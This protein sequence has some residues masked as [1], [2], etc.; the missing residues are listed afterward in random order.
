MNATQMA[1]NIEDLPGVGPAMAAAIRRRFTDDE[2]VATARRLDLDAIQAI[3]GISP[4]RAVE[5]VRA[6]TGGRSD[7]RWLATP[8]AKRIHEDI[9]ERL[10]ACAA[11]DV[12]RNRLRLLGPATNQTDAT[13]RMDHITRQKA[14]VQQLDRS[15]IR[16]LLRR[17]RPLKQPE[18]VCD[19][20]VQVVA[21]DDDVHEQLHALGVGRWTY[22]ASPREAGATGDL[23]LL[24][25]DDAAAD[26]PYDVEL[27][28]GQGLAAFAPHALARWVDVNRK[29]IEACRD[30]AAAMQRS[31]IAHELLAAPADSAGCAD[32]PAAVAASFSWA[33]TELERRLTGLSLSALDMMRA[34]GSGSLPPAID[35]AVKAVVKDAHAQLKE[36]TGHSFQPIQ[37]TM[38]LAVDEQ[39]VER[40]A[41]Q[42]GRAAKARAHG[43]AVRRAKAIASH[44]TALAAEVAYWFEF[45]ADFALG[46]FAARYDLHT[47]DFGTRFMLRHSV[48]LS[49]AARPG[50]TRIHYELGGDAR[51]AV[52]T[53]ANSG[54]KT[55]LLEHLAQIAIMARLGL[56]V[57]GEVQVPWFDEIHLVTANKGLD[58]GAFETF[59]RGFLPIVE[60]DSKRLVLADEI[61]SV[62]EL[63]AAGRILG[64]FL[65]RLA[66][67]SSMAVL[68]THM[69]AHI[70]GHV[71]ANVRVD[72]IEATGLDA[73]NQLIV[74]RCPKMGVLARSTPEL[75]VQR[76]V[77][78]SQGTRQKLFAALLEH[79]KDPKNA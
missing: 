69:A 78:T 30:L 39:E 62:T 68:V 71:A 67:S 54:G 64:F 52:L 19:T 15:H 55:T 17:L 14:R 5:L 10:L 38:P 47:P 16:D 25:Y 79:M 58:A 57:V 74:D 77:A 36:A 63:E 7:D 11:T 3:D 31:S 66:A 13:K 44:Q 23:T 37:A 32:V 75:I 50:V 61:E 51:L 49:L 56:P 46:C 59:L 73:E 41:D 1:T 40:V 72:G 65:D 18:P 70:L 33:E 76:M 12:G 21:S 27:H 4:K 53:G 48:H 8:G 35:A 42:L 45:D 60:G 6:V 2:F 24:A 43:A 34:M 28:I 29:T 26:V 20:T 9:Q 22:L